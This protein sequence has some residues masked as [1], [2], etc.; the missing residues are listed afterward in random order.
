MILIRK[1]FA[2]ILFRKNSHFT[3]TPIRVLC[4]NFTKIGR[5][6]L[7]ETMRCFGDKTVRKCVLTVILCPFLRG[8]QMFAGACRITRA[9]VP[10]GYGL[11][12]LF[13]KKLTSY[14]RNICLWHII[15]TPT[16]DI[17]NYVCFLL[18]LL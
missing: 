8:R 14:N 1:K 10:L 17:C 2:I 15:K 7:G 3:T 16:V 5:P 12:E 6:G 9:D 13:P 4:S 18:I 11:P